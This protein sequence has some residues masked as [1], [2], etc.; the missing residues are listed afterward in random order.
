MYY[1]AVGGGDDDSKTA[2]YNENVVGR[3]V[4]VAVV[5]DELATRPGDWKLRLRYPR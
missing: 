4:A 2:D 1:V 3:S 5:A